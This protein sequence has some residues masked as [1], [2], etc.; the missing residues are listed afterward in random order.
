MTA[1]SVRICSRHAGGNIRVL[2]VEEDCVTLEQELRD[3]SGWWFYWNFSAAAASG[4]TIRFEFAN[5]EVI[6]RHGPAVSENGID[7]RWLGEESRLSATAF[8]YTFREGTE[9]DGGENVYFCFCM[10]YQLHHFERFYSRIAGRENVR[11]GVLTHSEQ[12]RAVPF[13]TVGNATADR[14]I[15]FTARHHACE[16]APSYMLEGLLEGLLDARP[17]AGTSPVLER[18]M[19]HYVPFMDI[20]GVEN[21][22]QGKSRLPHDHNRDYTDEPIYSSTAALMHY[23]KGLRTVVA[24]DFHAPFKWGDRNDTPF[25]VKRESPVKEQIEAL[26]GLLEQ[27]T[28]ERRD[29]DVIRHRSDRDLAMGEDWN[30]PGS[31]TCAS[32]FAEIGVPLACS[33]EFPY[34]GDAGTAITSDNARRFGQDFARALELYLAAI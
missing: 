31:P 7:W 25:F 23:A 8:S 26:S 2:S 14:H 6:G 20:D 15:F 22:D 4:K 10:P 24:I 32:F 29:R 16:S 3:T 28:G 33:Y 19:I 11:R 5:G 1:A 34:C 9:A 13:L 27:T 17:A 21:G 12:L 30:M 18:F